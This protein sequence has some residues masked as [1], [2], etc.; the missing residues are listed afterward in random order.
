MLVYSPE[1]WPVRHVVTC[2]SY[3]HRK[4][5]VASLHVAAS[6]E[7]DH[8]APSVV[9]YRTLPALGGPVKIYKSVFINLL[10]ITYIA[11]K[12]SLNTYTEKRRDISET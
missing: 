6:C 1:S 11:S 12:D 3:T 10:K 4:D 9:A 7:G 2:Y 8:Q 5:G